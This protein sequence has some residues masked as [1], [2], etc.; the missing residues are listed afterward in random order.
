MNKLKELKKR[1]KYL[2]KVLEVKEHQ[3]QTAAMEFAAAKRDYCDVYQ[4]VEREKERK[5]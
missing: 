4:R 3:L 1:R 5:K 2:R